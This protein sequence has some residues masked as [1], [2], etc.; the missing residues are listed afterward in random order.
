MCC[1]S[2]PGGDRR[3]AWVATWCVLAIALA[4]GTASA[5]QA[6]A[7]AAAVP[8]A[9]DDQGQPAADV[10]SLPEQEELTLPPAA[11]VK[12]AEAPQ[13]RANVSWLLIVLGPL[14]A[15]AALMGL[16]WLILRRGAM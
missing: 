2:M 4:G 14:V 1:T 7:S 15:V 3:P 6:P 5:Q 8:L 10:P 9:V 13:H 12:P 16:Y 11:P